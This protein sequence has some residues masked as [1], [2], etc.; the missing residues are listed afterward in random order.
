MGGR[1]GGRAVSVIGARVNQ[2]QV[3][4]CFAVYVLLLLKRK[5]EMKRRF[6]TTVR[7]S[8]LALGPALIQ[9]IQVRH[10]V[11]KAEGRC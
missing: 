5:R 9:V 7:S 10:E 2:V 1:E 4:V 6:F 11:T 8:A 3:T